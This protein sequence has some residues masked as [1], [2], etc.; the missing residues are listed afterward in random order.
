MPFAATWMDL[1][2]IILSEVRKRKTNIWYHLNT[3]SERWHKWTYLW[4]RNREETCGCQVGEGL[5]RERRENLALADANIVHTQDDFPGGSDDKASAYNAGDLV[6][7]PGSG[8]SP[9]EGNGNPLQYSCL[10]KSH[11]RRSLVGYSPWGRKVSDTTEWLH[12]TSYIGWTNN[13]VLLYTTGN[14]IQYLGANHNE[15][16]YKKLCICI[17]E[18]LHYIAEAGQRRDQTSQS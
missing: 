17:T 9:R 1:E 7:I 4:N 6:R 18:S 15:K 8:R 2:I 5:R 3:E 14:Y 13:E 11:G 10:E 16:Q 12:F